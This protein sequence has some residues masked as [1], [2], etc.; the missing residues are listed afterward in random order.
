LAPG[1]FSSCRKCNIDFDLRK[2]RR[3]EEVVEKKNEKFQRYG[4]GLTILW[5]VC[6]PKDPKGGIKGGTTHWK[7][8]ALVFHTDTTTTGLTSD[9][10]KFRNERLEKRMMNDKN[11]WLPGYEVKKKKPF[12]EIKFEY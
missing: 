5:T 6:G 4:V 11:V 2:K 7:G 9:D 8:P 10:L 1:L 12:C 3:Y